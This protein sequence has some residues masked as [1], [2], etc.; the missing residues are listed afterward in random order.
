MGIKVWGRVYVKSVRGLIRICH[1]F[2]VG[3]YRT[4]NWDKDFK[5]IWKLRKSI[6]RWIKLIYFLAFAW[7][8]PKS[9][10]R[11]EGDADDQKVLLF[12]KKKE[13][14]DIVLETKKFGN[15]N[16]VKFKPIAQ[17]T[18]N[19]GK[20]RNKKKK[21]NWKAKTP[22]QKSKISCQLW[23]IIKIVSFKFI[24]Y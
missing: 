18:V 24:F 15:S 20:K 11:R 14:N 21:A 16:P 10:L 23:K 2:L 7:L 12:E 6:Y 22:S 17:T 9:R 1:N 8:E 5:H 19:R 4:F 3:T 13:D